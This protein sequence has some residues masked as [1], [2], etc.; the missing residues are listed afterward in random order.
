SVTCDVTESDDVKAAMDKA[1]E[2]F[3]RVDAAFNNAGV[4]QPVTATADLTDDEW[5]RMIAINL[6]GVFLCMK[7]EIPLMLNQGG[8]R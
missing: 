8:G 6:S 3:G 1:V 2:A 4:E 7:H 5:H